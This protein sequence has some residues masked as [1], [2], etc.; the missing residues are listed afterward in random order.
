VIFSSLLRLLVFALLRAV[1]TT[2]YGLLAVCKGKN[3]LIGGFS[4]FYALSGANC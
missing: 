2:I 1:K 4:G 3:R